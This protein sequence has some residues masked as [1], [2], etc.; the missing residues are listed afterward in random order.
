MKGAIIK[1]VNKKVDLKFCAPK[2]DERFPL[3]I[4]SA[5]AA[6]CE[7]L[8]FSIS[9]FCFVGHFSDPSS[10]HGHEHLESPAHIPGT[11][12]V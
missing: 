1:M 4:P 5:A 12:H 7:H 9:I 10:G 8:L 3:L 6:L 2:D 11:L